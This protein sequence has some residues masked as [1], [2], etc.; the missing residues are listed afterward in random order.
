[1]AIEDMRSA[2]FPAVPGKYAN[3][4]SMMTNGLCG[5]PVRITQVA[6]SRVY[7]EDERDGYGSGYKTRNN[8]MFMSDTFDEA[9]AVFNLSQKALVDIENELARVRKDLYHKRKA[10]LEALIQ[11]HQ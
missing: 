4:D 2:P 1:M 11:K 8:L 9:M 7:Y 3:F 10:D 6:K 5:Y